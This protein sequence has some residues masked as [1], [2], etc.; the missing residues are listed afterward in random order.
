[1]LAVVATRSAQAAVF[2]GLRTKSTTAFDDS[3][4]EQFIKLKTGQASNTVRP[5]ERVSLEA[6][7]SLTD[8]RYHVNDDKMQSR[9]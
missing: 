9:L 3:V 2:I 6:P 1:M 4:D 8:I 7:E 5:Y